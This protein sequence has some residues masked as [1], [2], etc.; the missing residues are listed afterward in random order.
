MHAADTISTKKDEERA[1]ERASEGVILKHLS[2]ALSDCLGW[3]ARVVGGLGCLCNQ[4]DGLCFAP[5]PLLRFTKEGRI[6]RLY[7]AF[8]LCLCELRDGH[9]GYDAV[10]W[11]LSRR[12]TP[13]DYLS[14]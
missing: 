4:P 12:A 14:P 1:S 9:G 11:G 6:P 13:I 7:A 5:P 8:E 10:L 2:R 3:C